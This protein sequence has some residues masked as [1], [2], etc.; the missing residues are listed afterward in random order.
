MILRFRE[1]VYCNGQE[2]VEENV[3]ADDEEYDEVHREQEAETLQKNCIT[4]Y[5]NV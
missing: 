4:R 5:L 2:D 3:I 1:I